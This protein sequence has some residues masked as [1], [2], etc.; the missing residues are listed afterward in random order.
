MCKLRHAANRAELDPSRP[1]G[2]V[3]LDVTSHLPTVCPAGVTQALDLSRARVRFRL[4]LPT[5]VAGMADARNGI[6]VIFKTRLSDEQFASI[7]TEWRNIDPSME[8]TFTEFTVPVS[9]IGAAHVETGANLS[10]VELVG[11]KV[12]LN[13]RSAT[14]IAGKI[15]LDNFAIETE[16]LLQWDFERLHIEREFSAIRDASRG[17]MTVARVFLCGG[18]RACP[19]FGSDGRVTGFDDGAFFDD[20][21][22]LLQAASRTGVRLIITV[23]DDPVAGVAKQVAGVQLGGRADLFREPEKR[24]AFFGAFAELLRRYSNHPAIF[25][26]QPINEPERVLDGLPARIPEGIDYVALDAMRDFVRLTTEYV[27]RLSPAH[28]VTIGSAQRGLTRLWA[29]LGLDGFGVH[30]YGPSV[31]EPFPF[32]QCP[33]D[34]DGPCYIEEVP[35]AS[36][37]QRATEFL[38]SAQSSGYTGLALWSCRAR[39]EYSDLPSALFDLYGSRP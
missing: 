20:F 13:S 1:N 5:G 9:T 18:W 27:H 3:L 7:Y 25:S 34:L 32:L 39:D 15:Y 38:E 4:W 37:S 8:N 24:Q 30:W 33:E 22:A 36:T 10:R 35:T 21:D 17:D 19:E 26:W 16:P 29:G 14:R 31:E 2:E 23:F 12:G 28:G 11:I 6:Q